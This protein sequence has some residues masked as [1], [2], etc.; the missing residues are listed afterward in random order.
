MTE[1][2]TEKPTV[3]IVDDQREHLHAMM[4]ILRD[5]FAVL[6]ATDGGKA[7]ELAARQPPPDLILLDV[8]MPGMDGYEVLHRLKAD[9]VTSDIP[10][11]F[12]TALSENEDEAKGLKLGAADY[13]IKPANPDL[14]KVRVMVQL[15]LRRHRKKPVAASGA[16]RLSPPPSILVVDDVPENIHLLVSALSDEYSV[17][18]ANNG[19]KTI[20][21]V[22]GATP[23]D[24]ILLDIMM[25]EMDGYEVCRR[26]KATEA[27]KSIPVIFLSIMDSPDKKVLGFSIGAA[28]YI[29]KPFD[30]D[31]VRARVRTHLLLSRLQLSLEL[32]I[33]QRNA[34][35]RA[36]TSQ[37]QAT[38]NAI[39]DLLFEMDLGGRYLY[40]HSPDHAVLG[41]PENEWV[42]KRMSEVLPTDAVTVCMAA[43]HEANEKGSSIG[44]QFKLTR[45]QGSIWFE[46]A[47]A[48]KSDPALADARFIILAR[49]ITERKQA[50]QE[51][52]K[53]IEELRRWHSVT[54]DREERVSGLKREVNELL[55]RLGEK[56]R[57]ESVSAAANKVTG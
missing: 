9:P 23:P 51:I 7:L 13:I 36:T 10:V 52:A 44:K 22:Q 47:V 24:L 33:A 27:G 43:L 56:P 42:G 16:G 53:Q 41:V 54:Q 11:I 34:A 8:R 31:E 21:L 1:I 49:D 30:I 12:V 50:E 25:P 46:L 28:D 20:E 40:V 3:L 26:I 55:T 39:P 19:P 5:K 14:L 15:E 37:L 32:Q 48:R 35:L 6:A 18:V 29:T 57:Y 38:L 17:L 2:T 4:N 45:P